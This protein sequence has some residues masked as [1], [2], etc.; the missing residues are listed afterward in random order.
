MTV[1]DQ[2]DQQRNRV[3]AGA[4]GALAVVGGEHGRCEAWASSSG[5]EQE[6]ALIGGRACSAQQAGFS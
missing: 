5:T 6:T 4:G 2:Q 1:N 3:V